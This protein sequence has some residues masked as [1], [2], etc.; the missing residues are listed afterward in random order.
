MIHSLRISF[1]ALQCITWRQV[2]GWCVLVW[3]W[4]A[5][6]QFYVIRIWKGL[7]SQHHGLD[8]LACV[9]WFCSMCWICGKFLQKKQTLTVIYFPQDTPTSL[10]QYRL[11]WWSRCNCFCSGW[12]CSWWWT[13][14]VV[15]E[16]HELWTTDTI[17][18]ILW[19]LWAEVLSSMDSSVSAAVYNRTCDK[20]IG[21]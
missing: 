21:N 2:W 4:F 20:A 8:L 1:I 15:G 16:T 6:R 17:R 12:C 10:I 19:S 11:W 9:A 14:Q 5:L 3:H 7:G 13:C 18:R